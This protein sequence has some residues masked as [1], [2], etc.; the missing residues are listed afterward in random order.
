MGTIIGLLILACGDLYLK[1]KTGLH[2]PQWISKK[3]KESQKKPKEWKTK[4]ELR[5]LFLLNVF[6]E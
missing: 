4:K 1:K 6:S 5:L 3:Y 2:F